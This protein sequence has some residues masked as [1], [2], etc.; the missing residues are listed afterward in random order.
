MSA[1]PQKPIFYDET[2]TRW[3]T[4]RAG[5]LF[6]ATISIGL[7]IALI[8]IILISPTLPSLGFGANGTPRFRFLPQKASSSALANNQRYQ[9]TRAALMRVLDR[10]SKANHQI[11]PTSTGD[12]ETIGFFVNWDDPSFTSLKKN[13]PQLDTVV[14]EWL[15]L[16][17]ASGT[18]V[19]DDPVRE[20]QAASYIRT[21]KP[22]TQIYELI[23]NYTDLAWKGDD[24]GAMLSSPDARARVITQLITHATTNGYN[25]ISIDF[26]NL[27]ESKKGLLA[28]FITE[29]VAQA[30][31]H[32]LGVTVNVPADDESYRYPDLAASADGV[33]IMAYDEHWAA[34]QPGP[35]ASQNWF[36]DI[37]NKRSRDIPASKLIV[38]IGNYSYD[39]VPGQDGQEL[40]FQDAVITAK[41]SEGDINL[42]DTSMNP[43]FQYADEQNKTHTVWMLD[44]VTAFNE[45]SAISD[46]KPKGVALW[47]LGGE[48][49]SIWNIFGNDA[50]M[51]SSTAATLRSIQYGY[52]ITYEGKGEILQLTGTPTPGARTIAFDPDQQLITT[53]E[54]TA[55]PSA[56]V[57]HRYGAQKKEIALTF[58][59]GPD[60]AYTPQILD[61]LKKN[62]VRAT[63]FI[64]GMNAEQSP[65]LLTRI[66]N[67]G[68]EIGSHTFTHP[69]IAELSPRAVRLELSATQRL[70][71]SLIGR[72]T[73]LFRPPYAEDVEPETPDQVAPLE[74]TSRLGYLDVGMKIDPND[75]RSPGVDE[76]VRRTVAQADAGNGNV[77]LLHDSGGDRSQT[78]VALPEIITQ[79]RAR[80]YTFVLVSDL[81]GKTKD[82][83]MPPVSSQ[84]QL[85]ATIG[86]VSF[87]GLSLLFAFITILG[88]FGIIIG[89]LRSLLVSLLAAIQVRQDKRFTPSSTF[90]P[91]VAVIVPAFNEERVVART[92]SSLLTAEHPER[93]EI[94]VVD[95][96]STDE[97]SQRVREAFAGDA[98]VRLITKPNS[99]KSDSL[100]L[101]ISQTAADIVICLDADTIFSHDCITRLVERFCDPA[102]G[103]VAGNAKVGNRLNVITRLQAI[104]YVTSQNLDRRAFSL[105]NCITVV[106]G[107]VGAWRRELVLKAGG[108]SHRT[109]AE[110]TDLTLTIREMGA[111]IAYADGAIALT[112]APDTIKG[113]L[114]QRFR[115]MYGTLQ[116]AWAH[117]GDFF[118]PKYGALGF[119]ALPSIVLFQI[120][121]PFV[122]PIMDLMLLGSVILTGFNYAM[123]PASA[124]LMGLR[125][126]LSVFVLFTIVD[127]I[128]AIYAF[129][130]EHREDKRLLFWLLWQRFIYRQLMYYV[131]VRSV[132]AGLRGALIGWN[133]VERRGTVREG[134]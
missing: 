18:V 52:D 65:D 117:R 62:N 77:V 72:E 73:V 126:V 29:L 69:N 12:Y 45:L 54:Y 127:A 122:S 53:E 70:F 121:F 55:F 32:H 16:T 107:A 125:Q 68:N 21:H 99:G 134:V 14:A 39:W 89:V 92:I 83:V 2:K 110:D 22:E 11:A 36:I 25:G 47:H 28:T 6:F 33:I 38:A 123:H 10:Q 84:D 90:S 41:E 114:K 96:G 86:G 130:I 5:G 60:P 124:S 35:I 101:G 13:L 80:G 116:A 104:E 1:Q 30:H 82:Q 57:I 64:V 37:L 91:S 109:L 111:R 119:V 76:I 61:I 95:D 102:V 15:H 4:I 115:W 48:D 3:Q 43:T 19:I 108:F 24:T 63:F 49:P 44:A 67:D 59:D 9:R 93:F 113:F 17:D 31:P 71:E 75:W 40:S 27:P 112:E 133:K 118:R 94:I 66:V 132:I 81:M 129:A 131:A 100:N 8:V 97:T 128:S 7:L 87:R 46:I 79:L 56:Y 23:N 20:A 85:T 88:Y 50:Q 78:V 51:T 98:R 26:E 58:D 105:L 103:A 74:A 42:D 106:P 34:G 120:L